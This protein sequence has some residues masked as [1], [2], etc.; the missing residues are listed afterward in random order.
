MLKERS[1]SVF[2]SLAFFDFLASFAALG[3]AMVVRFVIQE[4]DLTEFLDL[5]LWMYAMVG[6][7]LAL[8]QVTGFFATGLYQL[9]SA[10]T[11]AHEVSRIVF[12]VA[13]NVLLVVSGLY[14]FR[15]EHVSRLTIIYYAIVD[16]TLVSMR[17]AVIDRILARV[18]RKRNNMRS[19]IVVGTSDAARRITEIFTRHRTLGFF[20]RG[21]VKSDDQL[22]SPEGWNI[23]GQ[24]SD[25]EKI[26]AEHAPDMV[27]YTLNSYTD[28]ELRTLLDVCDQAGVN[29]KIVPGFS[30]LVA[31]KGDVETLEGIPVISI[32]EVPARI[33]MN[34]FFKRVFDIV[35][36]A[37]IIVVLSP[38]F[39]LL[40]ILIKI[41]SPGPV[42]YTQERMGLDNRPFDMLKFRTMRVQQKADS[43]TIWTTK[44]DPRVT[45]IGSIMRKLSIDEL[46][47]FVNV[48][49]GQMSV[50][51]PRPERPFF[52]EQFK[53]EYHHYMRRHAV[54]AGITGWAQINGLR[55]D[56]SIQERIEADIFYIENWSF[57]LDLKII[58]LTPFKGMINANAY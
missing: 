6:V 1:Q 37:A 15:L 26:L 18:N 44:N 36:S 58:I 38:F 48:L 45:V 7:I 34:R 23:L 9:R 40:A 12:A 10:T 20:V 35:F 33:G 17:H 3:M 52:V 41:T 31:A 29:L 46:P 4:P 13:V 42:F 11:A 55:G 24:F 39:L 50:V 49:K 28:Q 47:Q 5:E 19:V 22:D 32:R 54:K 14:F 16:V 21:Y 25:L 27:V 57:W 51:G 56:T 8:V 53:A 43:D 30:S 2:F